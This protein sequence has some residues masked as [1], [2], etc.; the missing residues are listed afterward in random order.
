[1]QCEFS[2]RIEGPGLLEYAEKYYD[3]RENE[4]ENVV[5][6]RLRKNAF[7]SLDDLITIGNWKSPRIRRHI[8]A[9]SD[10]D[11]KEISRIAL[12]SGNERVRIGALQLISGVSWA[13][14][15]VILHFGFDNQYPILDFRAL[16]TLQAMP[17][18]YTFDFWWEYTL[19][20]RQMASEHG[21]TMRVL[22]RALWQYSKE[23]QQAP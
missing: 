14:A 21:V 20:C 19:F 5:G 15:S 16:W 13:M 9:N 1:V 23:H 2:P 4:M 8:L 18:V 3:P 10:G 11:V 12:C 7:C 17:K 6:P 22:D